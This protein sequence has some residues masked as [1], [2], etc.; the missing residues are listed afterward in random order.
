MR[1]FG[2]LLLFLAALAGAGRLSAQTLSIPFELRL[3][4]PGTAA[5]TSVSAPGPGL[6]GFAPLAVKFT[7][8]GGFTPIWDSTL[9]AFPANELDPDQMYAYDSVVTMAGTGFM[10][11]NLR[12][13]CTSAPQPCL[14]P[15]TYTLTADHG[16]EYNTQ[17]ATLVI[18]SDGSYSA[19][20]VQAGTLFFRLGHVVNTAGYLGCD[21]HEHAS[22]DE[23]MPPQAR[24]LLD[25]AS[26]LEVWA[27]SAHNRFRY[28]QQ[29]LYLMGL[30]EAIF[31]L[32]SDE[33]TTYLSTPNPYNRNYP[34]AW[35][36]FNV[37]PVYPN[38]VDPVTF[39]CDPFCNPA[40]PGCQPYCPSADPYPGGPNP[41]VDLPW[42]NVTPF[43]FFYQTLRYEQV[44]GQPVYFQ[45]NHPWT[46]NS[47][48]I[49]LGYYF[50][51]MDEA[52]HVIEANLAYWRDDF[53]GLEYF[54]GATGL[55]GQR[56]LRQWYALLNQGYRRT[57]TRDTDGHN[58]NEPPKLF[59]TWVQVPFEEVADQ[60]DHQAL[61]NAIASSLKQGRAVFS[62][63]PYLRVRVAGQDAVGQTLPAPG[64][65]VTFQVD[66]Q[67][68]LGINVTSLAA[69]A[70]GDTIGKW[71][72]TL[73][74]VDTPQGPRLEW[75]QERTLTLP[76]DAWVVF[77]LQG[78]PYQP[79]MAASNPV[80]I[81]RDRDGK[82]A[83]R[84]PRPTIT[85]LSLGP[86][87]ALTGNAVTFTFRVNPAP[88]ELP[89]AWIAGTPAACS[90]LSGATYQGS[91]T[92]LGAA[93]ESEGVENEVR[94]TALGSSGYRGWY[95][96]TIELH[97]DSD[98]DGLPDWWES[99]YGV[100]QSSGDPDGDGLTNLQEYQAGT[101]PLD[102]DT[103]HDQMPDGFEV[104]HSCLSPLLADSLADPDHDGLENIDEF[105][106]NWDDNVSDP[107]D[108]GKPKI[109]RP[110]TG[111]FGDADG[112]LSIG[113]P[114]LDQV[115]LILSG[116]DPSYSRV[117]PAMPMVQDLDGSGT[118]GGPDLDYI[119]LMLSGNVVSPLGWPTDLSQALPVGVPA[120][121]VG[122]T[123]AIK[124]KLTTHGG[125]ERPGFGVVFRVSQGSATLYGGEGWGP[126]PASR[127]DLT[128]SAGQARMVLQVNGTGT[129]RVHVDL[130]AADPVTNLMLTDAVVLPAD[131][132]INGITNSD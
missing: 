26:G 34:T 21:F 110:G 41:V 88:V 30:R 46:E 32:P 80:W 102:R 120:I 129:I 15:D 6:I 127:Y 57:L 106:N 69:V 5:G 54:G 31:S 92:V 24:A 19:D 77:L 64:D 132:E 42:E 111:F 36:H 18:A 16:P 118:I 116:N 44:S 85:L 25:L 59:R 103:D 84:F 99:Q 83:P 70:N 35:G 100:H 56:I 82:I 29:T 126:E 109:G 8:A 87:P 78:S 48:G 124:V 105:Y 33:I 112:S 22:D 23:Q 12:T 39:P 61:A 65:T 121:Q 93:P 95:Y 51:M 122:H 117:Y 53:D 11:F 49:L 74:T 107:C 2:R 28:Y 20:G 17:A 76:N 96:G 125:L 66:I 13:N 119:Q 71:D 75:N 27:H 50:D 52:S 4:E 38:R 58:L 104:A 115:A 37:F 131:V 91:Y 40:Q 79:I 72:V 68:R 43:R 130:P 1:Q 128:N 90:V 55:G 9:T 45:V 73:S 63:G 97:A 7:P 113:G 67:A 60:P 3:I 98:R 47:P 14:T 114:D 62:L 86:V 101:N 81:D 123:V 94:I 10:H 89:R 108:E